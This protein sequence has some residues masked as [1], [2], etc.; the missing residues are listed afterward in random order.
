MCLQ[1]PPSR[2]HGHWAGLESTPWDRETIET[3]DAVI[4]ATD[5]AA[6]DYPA[7]AEWAR[8]IVD[9]RNAMAGIGAPAG[10]IRKA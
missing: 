10:K 7:L 5:H 3:Y 6:V 4:I 1:D 8:L 2:E 9:T